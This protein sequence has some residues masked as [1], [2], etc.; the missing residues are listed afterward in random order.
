[1]HDNGTTGRSVGLKR[2]LK[3]PSKSEHVIFISNSVWGFPY[4]EV[5]TGKM[6]ADQ[7]DEKMTR[8]LESSTTRGK[9][10][11]KKERGDFN[12]YNIRKSQGSD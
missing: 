11:N 9:V 10:T 2:F 6:D 7:T 4:D 1:M 3:I 5:P 8:L 12:C